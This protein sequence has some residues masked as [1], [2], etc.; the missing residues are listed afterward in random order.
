MTR[1]IGH[2]VVGVGG[3]PELDEDRLDDVFVVLLA[4]GADEIGL[5]DDALLEDRQ[6]G[7][8]VVVRVDPVADVLARAVEL[9]PLAAQHVRDLTGGM[10]FSTCWYGP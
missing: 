1:T 2:E 3:L 5:A 6:H 7:R 10:N 4:V 8:R 9:R